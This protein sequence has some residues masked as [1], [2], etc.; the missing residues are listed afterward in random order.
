MQDVIDYRGRILDRAR[1]AGVEITGEQLDKYNLYVNERV[2]SGLDDND[3]LD[4]IYFNLIN[5][6]NSLTDG[7]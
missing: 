5:Y 6:R 3:A 7:E 2:F 1:I 4:Y